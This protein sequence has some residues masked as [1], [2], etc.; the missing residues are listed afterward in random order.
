MKLDISD[1]T[2][3]LLGALRADF[4][5]EYEKNSD[6]GILFCINKID[7]FLTNNY[8]HWRYN[9]S[10]PKFI[11][12]LSMRSGTS[13][14]AGCLSKSGVYMGSDLDGMRKGNIKGQYENREIMKLNNNILNSI[15]T[16]WNDPNLLERIQSNM[17]RLMEYV[18]DVDELLTDEYSDKSDEGVIIGLKEPRVSLLLPLYVEALKWTDLKI[19]Y[20]IRDRTDIARSLEKRDGTNFQVAFE[21][22]GSWTELIN[23]H[24]INLQMAGY[25]VLR[26][27]DFTNFIKNPVESLKSINAQFDLN[28]ELDEKV[29]NDFIDP[30]LVNFKE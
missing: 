16:S 9:M 24:I 23:A 20:L 12:I 11:L 30:N 2:Y 1:S 8:Q 25:D 28:L 29:I 18:D 27:L 19:I 22:V 21:L 10:K 4:I 6:K 17:H 5:I 14:L 15:N 26:L 3:L 7:N 13:A